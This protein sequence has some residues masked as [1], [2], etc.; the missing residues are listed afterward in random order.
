MRTFKLVR[1]EDETGVSGVGVVAEGCQFSTG[2]C[3]LCWLNEQLSLK[4]Y[5]SIEDVERVH[6]H[7]G[8]TVIEWE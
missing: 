7:G 8:K 2:V 5:Q 4:I 6:G 1:N 3:V